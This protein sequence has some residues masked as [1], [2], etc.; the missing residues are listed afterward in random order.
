[1]NDEDKYDIMYDAYKNYRKLTNSPSNHNTRRRF[2]KFLD[3]QQEYTVWFK[4]IKNLPDDKMHRVNWLAGPN[5]E[6][7]YKV[8]KA[9]H[10]DDT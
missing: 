4:M 2:F 9:R 1:M 6:F 10:G 8:W 7:M 5:H 3:V